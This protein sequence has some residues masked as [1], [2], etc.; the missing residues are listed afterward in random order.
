MLTGTE[1]SVNSSIRG[2]E[3][4][5]QPLQDSLRSMSYSGGRRRQASQ[6]PIYSMSLIIDASPG[7]KIGP[8]LHSLFG[9]KTGQVEGFSYT[10]ANVSKGITW[11]ED[12]LVNYEEGASPVVEADQWQ[13]EYLENP[14]KY[15]PGTKMAF[16]GLKKPKD[17][18][19]LITYVNMV[20]QH[21]RTSLT[22]S[23]ATSEKPPNE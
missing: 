22:R 17:R 11:K 5:G 9:R 7:N 1:F 12:T 23:T 13:F 20:A 15:I 4:R 3:K 16:G 10:D 14:K 8:N 18:N 19:D 6:E 2:C 21:Q